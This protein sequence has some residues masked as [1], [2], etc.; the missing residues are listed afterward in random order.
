M[1]SDLWEMIRRIL[2]EKRRTKRWMN[3]VTVMM[4][5]V[6]FI[7]TY[8]LILPAITM[9]KDTNKILQC[10]LDVHSHTQECYDEDGNLTC[11]Q[12]DFVVHTH[13][14]LCYD[15]DGT[16][17]CVLPEIEAHTH[18]EDCYTGERMLTCEQE[19]SDTHTHVKTCYTFLPTCGKTEIILHTHSELEGCFDED[20]NLICDQTVITEHQHGD[21]CFTTLK[22][23]DSIGQDDSESSDVEDAKADDTNVEDTQ[24]DDDNSDALVS[25]DTETNDTT[26][27]M[28]VRAGIARSQEI[29][30][31][32]LDQTVSTPTITSETSIYDQFA[33]VTEFTTD[34]LEISHAEADNT[35]SL[36]MHVMDAG[37][38]LLTGQSTEITVTLKDVQNDVTDNLRVY[39]QMEEGN[40]VEQ[41]DTLFGYEIGK[42]FSFGNGKNGKV[43]GTFHKTDIPYRYY[44]ELS[45][46]VAGDT[47][48]LILQAGYENGT[49]DGGIMIAWLDDSEGTQMPTKSSLV[50]WTTQE[51]TVDFT[52]TSSENN[53]TQ[54]VGDG[55]EN[56][57]YTLTGLNHVISAT[58]HSPGD[59][60]K[61][62]INKFSYSDALTLPDGFTWQEDI[63]E[64]IENG[65]VEVSYNTASTYARICANVADE[66]GGTKSVLIAELTASDTSSASEM[67]D[68]GVS[69]E[70][71]QLVLNWTMV[72][73]TE[74]EDIVFP[75]MTVAYGNTVIE[76]EIDRLEELLG[77]ADDMTCTFANEVEM[78]ESFT[79]GDNTLAQSGEL[80][81]QITF[82]AGNCTLTKSTSSTSNMGNVRTFTLALNNT[83][84]LPYSK[85]TSVTDKMP[86]MYYIEPDRMQEMFSDTYGALLTIKISD[87]YLY[88]NAI[89]ETVTTISGQEVTFTRK[90]KSTGEDVWDVN[91]GTGTVAEATIGWNPD[92]TYLVMQVSVGDTSTTYEIGEDCSYTSIQEVFDALHACVERETVYTCTWDQQGQTLDIGEYRTF[93]LKANIKTTFMYLTEDERNKIQDNLSKI[94]NTAY[95]HYEEN[96][97][98]D[99]SATRG[100]NVDFTL[101]KSASCNGV[102]YTDSMEIVSGDVITYCNTVTKEGTYVY[103]SL[104]L[105][106]EMQGAQIL[107]VSVADNP[108]LVKSGLD[109]TMVNGASYYIMD[110]PGDYYD[111][112]VNDY[113]AEHINITKADSGIDT[114]ITW[115]LEYDITS[116]TTLNVTYLA[117][118]DT[119]RAG[120]SDTTKSTYELDNTV[121][122]NDQPGHRLYDTV[123]IY[124][125]L[126]SMDKEIVTNAEASI[127][128]NHDYTA[129]TL[130]DNSYVEEGETVTYRLSLTSV[131]TSKMTIRGDD[132][133]DILPKSINNYW[134]KDNITV[135]YVPETDSTCEISDTSEDAWQIVNQDITNAGADDEVE[136]QQNLTWNSDFSIQLNGT[137][138]I[139]VTATFPENTDISKLW[140]AYA[141]HYCTQEIENTWQVFQ[142]QDTV[143]HLLSVPTEGYLQKGVYLTGS[144]TSTSGTT[145]AYTISSEDDSRCYFS[146]DTSVYGVVTYYISLYNSG[147]SRMYLDDIQD[148]LPQGFT[149]FSFYVN[150]STSFEKGGYKYVS[151]NKGA[152]KSSSNSKYY[153]CLVSINDNPDV[154]F[155]TAKVTATT[156]TMEDG[157]QMVTFTLKS[158]GDNT[159]IQLDSTLNKYYL[160]PNEAV[161]FAYSCRT[162]AYDQELDTA[163]NKVA[164][165]AY[166]STGSGINLT[167]NSSTEAV[168]PESTYNNLT[169]NNGSSSLLTNTQAGKQGFNNSDAS[170]DTVWFSSDATMYRGEIKPSIQKTCSVE[171]AA[172]KDTLSWTV[173]A[174]NE[175]NENLWDYVLTD[176][177]MEPY[178]FTGDVTYEISDSSG[179]SKVAKSTLFSFKTTSGT[180]TRS[181]NDTSVQISY[182]NNKGR[183]TTATLTVNGA[184]TSLATYRFGTVSV[185]LSRDTSS[186]NETLSIAFTDRTNS[187]LPPGGSGKLGVN[188]LNYSNEL[189]NKSYVNNCYITPLSQSFDSAL[190]SKGIY[191][192]YDVPNGEKSSPSVT[193]Q[194]MVNVSYGYATAAVNKVAELDENSRTTDNAAS[195]NY[196]SNYIVLSDKDSMFRYTLNVT[197]TGGTTTARN[198]E[199]FVLATNLPE[200]GDHI[201]LYD[202]YPRYSEFEVDFAS[203]DELD[204]QV[205]IT[206]GDT[207]MGLNTSQ[208]TLQFSKQTGL[209]YD[210]TANED[211]WAGNELTADD[212]WYTLEQLKAYEETLE[213]QVAELEATM[214]ANGSDSAA[215]EAAITTLRNNADILKNMRS[216]RIVIKDDSATQAMMPAGATISISYNAIPDMDSEPSY[217]ETAWSS[218]GYVYQVTGLDD[219]LQAAPESV[220]V[221]IPGIP[222][223]SKSLI[224]ENGDPYEAPEDE[225]FRFLIYEGEYQNFTS[226]SSEDASGSKSGSGSDTSSGGGNASSSGSNAGAGND[227]SSGDGDFEITKSDSAKA[228]VSDEEMM[229]QLTEAN[230]P[231]TIAEITVPKGSTGSD[232]VAL[233]DLKVW[234]YDSATKTYHMVMESEKSGGTSGNT[235]SDSSGETQNGTSDETQEAKD[236]TW[237]VDQ[238]YT[239]HELSSDNDDTYILDSLQGKD[240]TSYTFKDEWTVSMVI[241]AVNRLKTWDMELNKINE[242]GD[243]SL[244]GVVFALYSKE[245]PA[246]PVEV[247]DNASYTVEQE[248]T[249]SDQGVDT[250]WYLT[251]IQTTDK[252]GSILWDDLRQSEYYVK[253]LQTLNGYAISGSGGQ[254]I[255][256]PDSKMGIVTVTVKNAVAYELPKTGGFGKL[257]IYMIAIGIMIF[258]ALYFYK[259]KKQ[260]I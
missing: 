14:A 79:F 218:F 155:K 6:V 48:S 47:M 204:F 35:Y 241:R 57:S 190:V 192:T 111:I 193:A 119:D 187:V 59:Y 161:V 63:R 165:K 213:T 130:T 26:P 244:T 254:M 24:A 100:V 44:L 10:P 211:L 228:T 114:C 198:M 146:N 229:R 85:N 217:S 191:T 2:A 86:D 186:G 83:G 203:L 7:T 58:Y 45:D 84:N 147:C 73:S 32:E 87:L 156:S 225:T 118:V 172:V 39:F 41:D 257:W 108:S 243:R 144:M 173:T 101:N 194:A 131:G 214:S 78:Q 215:I 167:Q 222:H 256:A 117:L 52:V 120:L 29:S 92:H 181:L 137:L 64:A 150:G 143:T 206:S 13:D 129:D 31:S 65:D 80:E 149:Y 175:G 1:L 88:E 121:W 54:L 212:G 56:E 38:T 199:L 72:P 21:G 9:E 248:L 34:A 240:A 97:L 242:T 151:K 3:A 50:Q 46:I 51:G 93:D 106:D 219:P 102:A 145:I 99:A 62:P 221:R 196:S 122:L 103:D 37:E 224:D 209:N 109:E 178:Q 70:D 75:S 124:G 166:D 68:V 168:A 94:Q 19:E 66:S 49:S 235:S 238:S 77:S 142:L 43:V 259:G 247:P 110:K 255:T 128:E 42:Q 89:S 223:L 195:S 74:G 188:T 81:S 148:I 201:T 115:Y 226:A 82:F 185:S 33:L 136:T 208:Y 253:E 230:I 53:K 231:F 28:K 107:L 27:S 12:A 239:I 138:Y 162:N 152:M 40:T 251:D 139:Y 98:E 18:T 76:A 245:Q 104:P 113:V 159:S 249:V 207:V 123:G 105:V 141:L 154:A 36:S 8:V 5:V 132:I 236:W 116:G 180:D 220:G 197:N 189:L 177:M 176:E 11:N 125:T 202:D 22:G 163:V 227:T 158:S 112:K 210:E 20:G 179:K 96:G 71:G 135:T 91:A 170:Y 133:L 17:V 233:D 171:T 216:L 127:N 126:L 174:G 67:R 246:T 4:A 232:S 95:R 61:N 25:D 200:E 153:N 234:T 16:L 160:D 23:D 69:I 183:A 205:S 90:G 140:T 164:M 169:Q 30:D 250:T 184:A 55:K 15:E 157:N 134:S 60:G 260:L 182:S 258:G 237:N 252:S